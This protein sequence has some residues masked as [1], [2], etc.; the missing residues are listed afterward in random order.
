MPDVLPLP[1][2]LR[3]PPSLPSA[4]EI[5]PRERTAR[6]IG[7]NNQRALRSHGLPKERLS[8][9]ASTIHLRRSSAF[10]PR[11]HKDA[12]F[13]VARP[14][15]ADP[16][17]PTAA[18]EHNRQTSGF[19]SAKGA[20]C[21]QKPV[22][23]RLSLWP[24]DTCGQSRIAIHQIRTSVNLPRRRHR[25]QG[26]SASPWRLTTMKVVARIFSGQFR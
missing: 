16:P 7:G 13:V 11:L 18:G 3:L 23:A 25:Q 20:R 4:V 10:D 22:R 24:A 14:Q 9:D 15:N 6:R 19:T 26:D 21:Q 5:R 12:H 17:P 2:G 8:R 1:A